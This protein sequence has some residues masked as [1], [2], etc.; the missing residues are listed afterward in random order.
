MRVLHLTTEF[1]PVIYGGLGT[2]VGG[3]VTASVRSGVTAGVL[4]VGGVLRVG[5]PLQGG[6]GHPSPRAEKTSDP[7]RAV[8]GPE[9]ITF[10]QVA[11][12]DAIEPSIRLARRWQP[13]VVHLH[14]AWVWQVGQAIQERIGIPLVYT[15][16]SVDRAEYELGE[17][18]AECLTHWE[19]QEAAIAAA[20]RVIAL[21]RDER[22]LLARYYPEARDRVRVVGNGLDD[23]AAA[24]RTA[25][26][27]GRSGAPLVLY[28]GRLVERKGIRELLAA[29]PAVLERAPTTRF[30][31]AG[32]PP[33]SS[34]AELERAW[35]PPSLQPCRNRIHFTGWLAAHELA[36][37]Y[38]AADILVVPSR[39][40]PF[41]MVILEGM[42]HGLPIVATAV[43]GPAEILEHERTGLL[44]PPKDSAALAAALLC[45]VQDAELGRRLGA[46]AAGEVRRRWL[47]P[48]AVETMRGVYQEAID[49]GGQRR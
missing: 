26:R 19:D 36:E 37:W 15:V 25:A 16:H 3:L 27:R 46:A 47:W 35:L 42:L 43:G 41:G 24:R 48:A 2:A 9:G 12:S 7:E 40:E 31:L 21:T 20:D 33:H 44:C 34:A 4:L 22:D 39:Y 23:C 49:T 38:R 10:F 14:T 45:L 32:G 17:G 1:P 29:I 18:G 5:E 8:V 6:Y 28:S 11:P 13:D 30:V